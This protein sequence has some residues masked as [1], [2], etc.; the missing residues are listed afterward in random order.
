[1]RSFITPAALLVKVT[2]RIALAWHALFDQ[3]RDA[4]GDDARLAGAGA[5]QHEQRAFGR[6]HSFALAFVQFV[7]Q[8]VDDEVELFKRKF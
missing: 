3:M 5:G 7:E 6:Q 4:I 1:M 8:S 2:A